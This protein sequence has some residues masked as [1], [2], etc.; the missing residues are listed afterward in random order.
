MTFEELRTDRQRRDEEEEEGPPEGRTL[1]YQRMPA[2]THVTIRTLTLPGLLEILTD[3]PETQF[4]HPRLLLLWLIV[5]YLMTCVLAIR[6][7][8][9]H[10]LIITYPSTSDTGRAQL[11][12]RFQNRS[13]G[14]IH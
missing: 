5:S 13:E 7:L 6:L 4:P 3:S 1:S 14:L 2:N 8:P 11:S 12:G 9:S 10:H